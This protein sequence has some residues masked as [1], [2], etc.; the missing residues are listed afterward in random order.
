MHPTSYTI[1]GPA[2]YVPTNAGGGKRISVNYPTK[3]PECLI[4]NADW[5]S[6][7]PSSFYDEGSCWAV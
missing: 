2:P 6:G 5:C 1:P 7:S 3:Y 4:S